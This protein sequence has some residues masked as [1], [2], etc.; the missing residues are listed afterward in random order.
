MTTTRE[1]A[2]PLEE[3]RGIRYTCPICR[4]EIFMSRDGVRTFYEWGAIKQFCPACGRDTRDILR[5][6]EEY[7]DSLYTLAGMLA[8]R[9]DLKRLDVALLVDAP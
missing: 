8:G 4:R 7:K 1:L 5:W 3:V 6:L 2:V 9:S